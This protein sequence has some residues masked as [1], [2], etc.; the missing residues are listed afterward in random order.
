MSAN[1]NTTSRRDGSRR[2]GVLTPD[3]VLT[4][5]DADEGWRLRHLLR[6]ARDVDTIIPALARAAEANFDAGRALEGISLKLSQIG[7]DTARAVSDTVELK[8]HLKAITDREQVLRR[9]LDE[10]KLQLARAPAVET[11]SQRLALPLVKR[12]KPRKTKKTKKTKSGRR[13]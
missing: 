2:D 5:D 11:A 9:E 4:P 6:G 7:T 13:Q 12:R 10:I 8:R 1:G 3:A